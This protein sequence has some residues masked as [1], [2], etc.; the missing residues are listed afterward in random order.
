VLLYSHF[1]LLRQKWGVFCV[2]DRECISKLVKCFL[3]Q[4]NAEGNVGD[5]DADN[6]ELLSLY[7]SDNEATSRRQTRYREFNV[8]HDRRIPIVLEK[9]LLFAD[10]YVFKR[11]LKRYAVR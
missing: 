9:G 8:K 10:S 2:L 1:V 5:E 7:G 4:N 3:S 6:E 11:A